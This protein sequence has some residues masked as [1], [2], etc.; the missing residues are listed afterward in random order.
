MLFNFNQAITEVIAEIIKYTDDFAHI[1]LNKVQ[2]SAA[3]NRKRRG[4]GLLAYVLPLRYKDGSS[5]QTKLRGAQ[6]FHF[7]ILPT[8]RDGAEILYIL[9]FMLPRFLNLPKKDKLETIV[10]ELY[11][12]S[13]S[14][15][16][17]L[18]RLKGRSYVHGKSL[19]DYDRNI[20][21]MCAALLERRPE[22]QTREIFTRSFKELSTDWEGVE[23]IHI[24]EPKPKLIHVS[25]IS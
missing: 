5:T 14:F 4:T 10:H 8:Y 20:K 15:N 11:H 9:Y 18:R 22:L 24:P 7:S 3:F 2:I 17:D 21:E 12:I 1:D 16:G 13:P 6:A 23:A 19:K 25:A